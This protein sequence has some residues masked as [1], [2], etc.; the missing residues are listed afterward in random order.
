MEYLELTLPTPEENLACD[1]ALV[2]LCEQT[3]RDEV[4]RFWSPLQ[5]FVVVGYA[6][7]VAEEVQLDNCKARNVPVLRRCS[8]GGTVLQGPGCLNYSLILRIGQEPPF[9]TITGT[10][11]AV[12]RAHRDA[13]ATLVA[14]EVR[15]D[16]ITDLVIGGLKICGNA[17]RR[18]RNFLLFHGSFLLNMDFQIMEELLRI[19]PKQPTYRKNRP[20]GQFVKNLQ[21]PAREIIEAVKIAWSA[22]TPFGAVPSAAIDQL[23]RERYGR[24]DWTFK[25]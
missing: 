12:M 10:N 24:E 22:T 4:L 1:E 21:R 17:Q 3:E 11:C 9:D 15:I 6:N 20:H 23:V 5:H 19:P 8:G 13:I 18:K 7:R 16:G 2:D 25:F 14:E